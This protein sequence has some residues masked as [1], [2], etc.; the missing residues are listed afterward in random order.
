MWQ[1]LSIA[2]LASSFCFYTEGGP[3]CLFRGWRIQVNLC[4]ATQPWR[5]G[6]FHS[7]PTPLLFLM[8]LALMPLHFVENRGLPP[9]T[10]LAICSPAHHHSCIQGTCANLSRNGDGN[11]KHHFWRFFFLG[12]DSTL[13]FKHFLLRGGTSEIQQQHKKKGKGKKGTE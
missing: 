6:I 7:L 12:Q 8:P 10:S 3:N 13:V 2:L 5:E 4:S 1:L 11:Q 9:I